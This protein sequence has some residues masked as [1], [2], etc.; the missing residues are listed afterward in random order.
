LQDEAAD[1]SDQIMQSQHLLKAAEEHKIQYE[2][3]TEMIVRG[4][5]EKNLPELI[6]LADDKMQYL[7][8]EKARVQREMSDIRRARIMQEAPSQGDE[9]DV[10]FEEGEYAEVRE[11]ELIEEEPTRKAA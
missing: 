11:D 2:G 8:R 4:V 1:L 7:L 9:E 5:D 3:K 10:D 6:D